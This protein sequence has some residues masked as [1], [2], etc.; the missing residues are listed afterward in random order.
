MSQLLEQLRRTRDPAQMGCSRAEMLGIGLAASGG[1]GYSF[2]AGGVILR[3]RR[4]YPTIGEWTYCGFARP[5]ESTI[6]SMLGFGH[7]ANMA[8]EYSAAQVLGN[9][10]AGDFSEPARL[11]FD[12]SGNLI[13]A[14]LPNAP[15]H[16]AA[17]PIAAGKFSLTWEYDPYG[18][19]TV[20][21]DFQVFEGADAGSV[22][23]SAPLTDSL[24]GLNTVLVI[25]SRRRYEFTTGAFSDG[26]SHVF[27]VRARNATPTAE[28]NTFTSRPKTARSI[29]ASLTAL[30]SGVM[31]RAAQ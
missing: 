23:Y 6:T 16:V 31:R 3:R 12:G 1:L 13:T 26:S 28:K 17:E 21:T 5:N 14:R 20:P 22:N 19:G 7:E 10:Y 8:Y 29:A 9:G 30:I 11:D 18:Q 25:G 4:L 27:A 24:T 15:L 2:I